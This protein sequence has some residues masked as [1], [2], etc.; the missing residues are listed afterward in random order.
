M[1]TRLP[2]GEYYLV[3]YNETMHGSSAPFVVSLFSSLTKS[4]G[5]NLVQLPSKNSRYEVMEKAFIKYFQNE[6]RKDG[7]DADRIVR[8]A[9][10]YKKIGLAFVVVDL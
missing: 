7:D 9:C 10:L 5:C 3:V 8:T 4:Y 2:I 1:E 6:P